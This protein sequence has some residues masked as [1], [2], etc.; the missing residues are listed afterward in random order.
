M[1]A[2]GGVLMGV[3]PLLKSVEAEEVMGAL[4]LLRMEEAAWEL[5]GLPQGVGGRSALEED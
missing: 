1:A 4:L 3:K 5:S 2:V